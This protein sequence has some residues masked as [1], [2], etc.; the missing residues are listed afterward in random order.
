MLI[1]IGKSPA[2]LHLI[3]RI[4]LPRVVWIWACKNIPNS[5]VFF[6]NN[7][8]SLIIETAVYPEILYRSAIYYQTPARCFLK[9]PFNIKSWETIFESFEFWQR[10]SVSLE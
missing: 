9:N 3:I 6:I 2:L 4:V 8:G 7:H 5:Y 10:L 1:S